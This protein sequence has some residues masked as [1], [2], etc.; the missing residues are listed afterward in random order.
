MNKA[1]KYLAIAGAMV[2]GLVAC[3]K[4]APEYE[5]APAAGTAEVFFAPTLPA[6][7]NLKGNN[8]K[9]TIEV[10]RVQTVSGLTVGLSSD[11]P[12]QFSVPSSVSFDAGS[13][14]AN[15][16]ITFDPAALEEE[17]SYAF[18]LSLTDETTP[19]GSAEYSFVA[20]IPAAWQV[21]GTG[22]LTEAAWWNE[23]EPGKTLLYQELSDELWICKIEGCF[24]MET[25]AAGNPYDVQ[26]YIFYWNKKTDRIYIPVHTMGYVP[27]N[28]GVPVFYADEPAFY[29]M[30]WAQR[31]G[32]GY[33]AGNFG[34]GAG[35]EEGTPE[36]FEFCDAFRDNYPE[37]YYP[38]YDGNGGFN[39]ADQYIVGHPGTSD[40]LGRYASGEPWDYFIADGFVRTID[41]NGEKYF[42]ESKALYEGYMESV[43]FASSDEPAQFE[44]SLRYDTSYQDDAEYD[45]EG[46]FDAEANEGLT[47]TYY[48]PDYFAAG[49]CLAFTAPVP[50]LLKDGDE[51]TDVE[52]YQATGTQFMGHKLYVNVKKGSVS[53][54]EDSEFPVFDII[55][56]V[57][58]MVEEDDA[59]VA[60]MS[61]GT[62]EEKFYALEYGKDNYTLDDIS[63]ANLSS[64]LGTWNMF[65]T[66][67]SDGGVY[68]YETTVEYAGQDEEDGTYYV[69][70]SNL[71]GSDGSFGLVDELYAEWDTDY[72]LLWL[73]GQDFENPIT[74]N[75]SEYTIGMYPWDP[76]TDKRYGQGN[77]LIGG[78]TADG[79]LAFVNLY[80][81]VNLSGICYYIDGL[82]W[83][84][85][86]YNIYGIPADGT[87]IGTGMSKFGKA[88]LQSE[89]VGNYVMM[90]ET[91]LSGNF[92]GNKSVKKAA[93][94][95]IQ[96]RVINM[97]NL[98]KAETNRSSELV[99][100]PLK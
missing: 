15:V 100:A 13:K 60:D 24:G 23:E 51:I 64:Y 35:Q 73:Y 71:S 75:E 91:K 66:D 34:P 88:R 78:L 61:F 37:D 65:S 22:T 7:Y 67:F 32:A 38:T 74:Y 47:T 96:N 29:N 48:L 93:S 49:Q 70:I 11:A 20:S 10:N 14:T 41:Y 39:L 27:S 21:F 76:D 54:E 99:S 82:G 16:D 43:L 69:K 31:N 46:N 9:F 52:N 36:W 30:Y 87:S 84:A 63:G 33:G 80:D 98:M 90:P 25:I 40:Y 1:F 92:N 8:G 72:G 62:A 83:L 79:V 2:F 26:D 4:K 55:L 5:P 50:E 44:Q 19:Y 97:K 45:E 18:K 85:K 53:F 59:L 17:V 42:G 12:A 56:T 68:G 77:C 94:A 3:E 95:F 89:P 81:G 6:S 86:V 28:Y 57:Y 58:S